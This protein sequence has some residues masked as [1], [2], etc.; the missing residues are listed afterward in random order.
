ML[1]AKLTTLD[2]GD[3]PYMCVLCRDTF[4]RSDI[5]KRHF[6][7]CSLRRGNPS[8]ATHLSHPSAHL[9]KDRNGQRVPPNDLDLPGMHD[10]SKTIN[11]LPNGL[12]NGPFG[13]PSTAQETLGSSLPGYIDG[14]SQH[15]SMLPINDTQHDTFDHSSGPSSQNSP[16]HAIKE[17]P[18]SFI[19]GASTQ[20]P[21]PINHVDLPPLSEAKADQ[22]HRHSMPSFRPTA[23]STQPDVDWSSIVS[24]GGN[25]DSYIH[26]MYPSSSG[27]GHNGVQAHANIMNRPF[28][29]SNGGHHDNTIHG[30]YV[31]FTSM[32]GPSYP[33]QS[34]WNHLDGQHGSLHGTIG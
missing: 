22:N 19:Y 1:L 27:P 15:F 34:S 16:T 32:A 3:R 31:P 11:G 9:K 7:K 4:S 8:G 30:Q 33:S 29:N 13:P 24:S 26:S 18:S 25:Q 12:S 17:R 10:P 2:T 21:T 23:S 5:L 14:R 6:Q 28:D 20:P